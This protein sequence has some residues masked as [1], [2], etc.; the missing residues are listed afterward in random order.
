MCVCKTTEAGGSNQHIVSAYSVVSHVE[1]V[2]AIE[3]LAACQALEF[4]HKKSRTTTAPLEDVYKLVRTVV[5]WDAQL[6]KIIVVMNVFHFRPWD[7]DRYMAPDIESATKLL[8]EGKVCM[9]TLTVCPLRN[10]VT[11]SPTQIWDTVEPYITHYLN[12]AGEPPL[13]QFRAA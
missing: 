5:R 9:H 13:K 4:H 7:K 6:Q 1:Q 11:P 2:L 8:R 10:N 12:E 3:L